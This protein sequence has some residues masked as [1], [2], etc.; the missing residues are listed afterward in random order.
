MHALILAAALFAPASV[1]DVRAHG[2]VGDGVAHDTAAIQAAVDACAAGG[3]GRVVFPPGRYRAGTIALRSRVV[4]QIEAGATLLGTDDLDAYRAAVPPADQPEAKFGE[5]WHRA[6]IVG[7][8]LEDVGILGDGVIDGGKV[9]DPKGEEGLRGPHT[10]LLVGC[11]GVDVRDVTIRD[12]GNYA[13][14][15]ER[16]DDL[17]IRDVTI[18]GGWD[19]VHFRGGPKSPCRRLSVVGCRLST[20]DDAIAG[21]Y[22]EDVTVRD[23]A[24][25]SSCN[26]VR[27]I[28]PVRR[29][30]IQDGLFTGPGRHPHESSGRTNM[31]AGILLQPGAW[32]PTEGELDE[33]LVSDVTM[34]HVAAPVQ[35][36][37]RGANRIGTVVVERLSATGV[38]RAALSIENAA[39]APAGR[40]VV[41]GVALE[42]AGGGTPEQARERWRGPS[43]DPRPLPA[44][45][46]FAHG[47]EELVLQDVRLDRERDDARP[48]IQCEQV[49]RLR[50][51]DLRTTDGGA[52][53][54]VLL[55][56][57]GRIDP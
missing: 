37:A 51:A 32:D 36:T 38:Y 52:A 49:A 33:V 34:R 31:L 47:V 16:T 8:G 54:S 35:I 20:G 12:S 25:D 3:G 45:G 19:G 40:V 1:I 48:A 5:R 22:A 46:L 2:A 9:R 24:I 53:E 26:G 57:V 56:G 43:I 11:R 7:E 17:R 23:C 41:R 18:E 39:E 13:I 27:I 6:L 21:R 42:Y 28:G 30:T 15:V 55:H 44:W 29:L 14:L 10:I 50:R 4:L